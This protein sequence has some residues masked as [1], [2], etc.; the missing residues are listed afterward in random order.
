MPEEIYLDMKA[1]IESKKKET[2]DKLRD[3]W[4]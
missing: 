1:E 3:K 4:G 2:I